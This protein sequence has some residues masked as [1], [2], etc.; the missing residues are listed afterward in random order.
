MCFCVL[1]C[2][3]MDIYIYSNVVYLFL[4]VCEY[5][6]ATMHIYHLIWNSQSL[7]ACMASESQGYAYSGS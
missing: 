4:G 6:E 2:S 1:A 7:P 5:L 3:L